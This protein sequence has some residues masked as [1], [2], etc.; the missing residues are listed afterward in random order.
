MP[1]QI[2]QQPAV[3]CLP[4]EQ[5]L[6]HGGD[7]VGAVRRAGQGV[8]L[9]RRGQSNVGQRRRIVQRPDVYTRPRDVRAH[10]VAVAQKLKAAVS[11]RGRVLVHGQQRTVPGIPHSGAPALPGGV[12]R[13][14]QLLRVGHS[15]HFGLAVFSQLHH[16]HCTVL[17]QRSRP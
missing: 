5:L 8:D 4:D 16:T 6:A 9:A 7:Y 13:Q 3:A 11:E 10:H 2:G 1:G 12:A 14:D 15:V 17:I